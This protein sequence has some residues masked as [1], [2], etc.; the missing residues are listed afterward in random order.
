MFLHKDKY[1]FLSSSD[2]KNFNAGSFSIKLKKIA[3]EDLPSNP[4]YDIITISSVLSLV[5]DL[6][7]FFKKVHHTCKQGGDVFIFNHFTPHRGVL[8]YLDFSMK[9]VGKLLGFHSVFEINNIFKCTGHFEVIRIEP[10]YLKGYWSI[11]HLKSK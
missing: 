6:E 5:D 4:L 9:P 11:I 3:F 10:I 7:S 2:L 8:R 1:C